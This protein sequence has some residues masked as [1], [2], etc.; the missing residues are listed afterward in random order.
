[1]DP[2]TGDLNALRASLADI[3]SAEVESGGGDQRGEERSD[4]RPVQRVRVVS[5][6][7]HLAERGEPS[8]SHDGIEREEARYGGVPRAQ[9]DGQPAEENRGGRNARSIG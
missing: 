7:E 2:Q 9:T 3:R 4:V 1:C 6:H 8:G 5:R